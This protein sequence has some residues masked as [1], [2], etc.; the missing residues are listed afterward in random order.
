MD[1]ARNVEA[2]VAEMQ[3]PVTLETRTGDTPQARRQRQKLN[4]PD[5]LLTTPEQIALLLAN[6]DAAEYF[7][8]LKCIIIDEIH[9]LVGNKRGHL[10]ALGLARLRRHAPGL[11]VA[12]LSATAPDPQ[13]LLDYLTPQNSKGQEAEL[14]RAADGA[15]ASVNVL[16][17]EE[18]IPWSGHSA[19]HAWVEVYEAIRNAI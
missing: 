19:R 12:G 7:K 6:P 4:P 1:I 9:A 13:I 5:I 17:S 3:L 18:R 8:D 15:G 11:R 10:L 2:P 14:I 16:N